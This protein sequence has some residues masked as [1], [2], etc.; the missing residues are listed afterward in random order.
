MIKIIKD[1]S[2]DTLH[3]IKR[4]HCNKCGCIFDADDESYLVDSYLLNR[5][6]LCITIHCPFCDELVRRNFE[7]FEA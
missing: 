4:F 5:N 2:Y 3:S 6:E 7:D 1:G